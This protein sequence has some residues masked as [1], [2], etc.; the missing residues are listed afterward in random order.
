M[1]ELKNIIL[2]LGRNDNPDLNGS[3]KYLSALTASVPKEVANKWLE[4][5]NSLP[6]GIISHLNKGEWSR[7]SIWHYRQPLEPIE[8]S[9]AKFRDKRSGCRVEKRDELQRRFSTQT[10]SVQLDILRAFLEN[11]TRTDTE[12]VVDVMNAGYWH[13]F[14]NILPSVA[15]QKELDEIK[16]LFFRNVIKNLKSNSVAKFALSH[17]P[18]NIILENIEIIE[19]AVGYTKLC[20]RLFN[21]PAWELDRTKL[22]DLRYLYVLAETKGTISDDRLEHIIYQWI[23]ETPFEKV[24]W[25]GS[26]RFLKDHIEISLTD[27]R[28]ISMAIRNIGKLGNWKFLK[29]FMDFD[30]KIQKQI[31]EELKY[32]TSHG[33]VIIGTQEREEHYH[34]RF[35]ELA[36]SD[37]LGYD[38]TDDLQVLEN[39][40]ANNPDLGK[41][42]DTLGLKPVRDKQFK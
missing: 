31:N 9:I 21:C 8:N 34:R 33:F 4:D 5:Y 35:M 41:L 7:E 40:R 29:D 23:K 22:D 3:L 19:K 14:I 38:I 18:E 25:E 32:D 6:H 36:K 10:W 15:K 39:L 16:S 11:D 12:F 27:I 24:K 26:L 13:H 37:L 42:I 17:L 20:V 1:D 2:S 28:D 30:Y